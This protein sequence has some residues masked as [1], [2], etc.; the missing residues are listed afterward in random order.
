MLYSHVTLLMLRVV[1]VVAKTTV[2]QSAR[3]LV[4]EIH[5]EIQ[6]GAL[7]PIHRQIAG[8]ESCGE[9]WEQYGIQRSEIA[10]LTVKQLNEELPFKLGLSI[11]DSCWTERI[12]MEQTIAFLREGV[13]QCSCCQT[14]GCNKKSVPVV[15]VIGPGKSSSTIAVQNLLQ[16]FRIPQVGYSAT[17]PDLSDKEQFGYFLRVVPSDVFQAQAINRLLH[18]YNWTYVAVLYSAGNYGEKGF[19]SLE[20]LIAHR[21]SSVCIA[22][23]EKIKTLASDQEYRQVLTRLDSQNSRPQVVVCF[24]EGASMRQ[25]FKAQKHLADGKGQMKR[26]QWIGSDGWAD[27][28]DVVEDL[29]QEAEGSFSI[30]IH[31]PKIPG[32]RQY[33]TALHPENNTMN[34]W[35]REFW[36]QKFNCQFAV[37]KEDKNNENIRICSGDENLDEQ[38]KEDPKLSQVI[39]SIRVVALGLKA[40]YQDRCRDNSTLCTE[41]LSRN[42]TLLYEYLLNVTYSDQFKQPVYFDRNGDPPA[43]YDILNYIGTKDLDNPY[44]E[45][46][47]FKSINDYGVEELDMTASSMFYD[48]TEILPESVCSRPCGV[49]QR[50]R[51]TMACCWICESC[52]D[53]QFVNKTTNQC[54]NCSLGSWPNMN[55]TGCEDII[56]EVVSWTSFGHILA[57]VLAVT[58]IITSLATLAVFLRHNS[59]PVV[60]STTRELSY[61][62]LSGLVACYAVSFALLATPSTSSCFI[63][64][65][66]PPIAFAVVYSALLTKTN[67]IARILAGSKKRILTK[68]PR[69]LTTFSQ[70]VITWILVAVQCVIVGVGLMRDWPDATYAKYALPRKLILECDT[71]TK[72]FLI[73]FFWDFFL[74]TLCTLYAFKTRNLPENF[75]EAKFIGFTMYCTVVVWIA[76]LVLHMG[77]THKALVMSFSYSLSASVALALLFFPK[78]Y[79]IL[80]H[81]EKNIRASYTTTKLIRCHFGNS[82]AA[83]DSTSKQQHLG[84][85]TT[86]RTSVQSGSASKSS[87]MGGGVTR[88]ASVHV[89]VSRGSTHSTDVSTQTE[90]ASKFSRSFSIVGRKKQQGLDDDVQQLD[91]KINSSAANL[92]LEEAEDEV[93]ALLA[94]SIENSM[95]TVLSTVAG[96]AVVPMVPMVPMVP[97]I[98]VVTVPTAPPQEDNFE[99]QMLSPMSSVGSVSSSRASG[100]PSPHSFDHL[101]DEELAHISVR[102]LNQKLMGQDRNVVMQWKQ[103]R[104]TLKNRGY[105]LNCRARRVQN[106]MQ[107]ETDNMMLRNQIKLLKD[108]LTEVQM[109]LQYYE[110]IFYQSYQPVLHNTTSSTTTTSSESVPAATHQVPAD[111]TVSSP[112]T[113]APEYKNIF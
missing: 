29:E 113:I 46:G 91:E 110:P 70:V 81:P 15:A 47:S 55:R 9:I 76:F 72:S 39:N 7:F 69:F 84:S 80:M 112:I 40:M 63:T 48:K 74:I 31:A 56:P 25:F 35:F 60:K 75:N 45:V 10:M 14:P 36:Q 65:V 16:V 52:L 37:S 71:E 85:K 95:R 11:R 51:E 43:W 1:D 23:S 27:R 53:F 93:G 19:E 8:S 104:R 82:Q 44:N 105:A 102:Q 12:A 109:R 94:D 111:P 73:P 28:N 90:A 59:T 34:P 86:A 88:T 92:L 54:M 77:T 98:P 5:G 62:I 67:R 38:Y 58:G 4:A 61:I 100:S 108:T 68:K 103:K 32:F 20:R 50:Q 17:T 89:P 107:L 2:Q 79:I 33:Y 83:Y 13:A 49:G 21:S 18:H 57:L 78:L 22:Y 97:V 6:I 101:S 106:Q 96:K 24:C 26:F 66:I 3:M 87:S 64:R 30:R 41:M 99:Q 42:G